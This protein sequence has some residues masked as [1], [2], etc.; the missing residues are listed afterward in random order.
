MLNKIKKKYFIDKLT[1]K[2][3]VKH[4]FL[5]YINLILLKNILQYFVIQKN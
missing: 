1:E 4:V 2:I 3:D 5:P